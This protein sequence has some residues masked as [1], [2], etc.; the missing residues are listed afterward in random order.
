MYYILTV[1]PKIMQF[2]KVLQNTEVYNKM[3]V[4]SRGLTCKAKIHLKKNA[5]HI[6]SGGL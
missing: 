5:Q 2:K 3:L 1:H 4:L 6:K